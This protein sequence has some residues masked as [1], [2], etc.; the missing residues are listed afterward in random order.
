M[1]FEEAA[2]QQLIQINDLQK[3]PVRISHEVEELNEN[4]DGVL[5]RKDTP[6][7][8]IRRILWVD[9]YP[10]NNA[11]IVSH[12]TNLGIVVDTALTT[13]EGL[14]RFHSDHY[15]LIIS[16]M[17]RNEDGTEN[18]VAGID[19]TKAIRQYDTDL[20]VIIFCSR[21]ARQRYA[22]EVLTSGVSAVTNSAVRL[23]SEIS[24]IGSFTSD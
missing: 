5:P 16:D 19:L 21:R 10:S 8:K 17:G 20:P 6:G 24:R 18:P 1:S 9:D 7:P 14:K 11:S 4:R 22:E 23:L 3:Q 13:Q 2:K 12:L 15:N